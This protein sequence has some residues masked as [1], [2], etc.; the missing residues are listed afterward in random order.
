MG[1]AGVVFFGSDVAGYWGV[2]ASELE[3][4]GAWGRIWRGK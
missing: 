4:I 3:G 2:L 1:T